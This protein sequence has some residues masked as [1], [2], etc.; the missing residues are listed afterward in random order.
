MEYIFDSDWKYK[1]GNDIIYLVDYNYYNLR[2][3]KVIGT[4][5]ISSGLVD[6][7]KYSVDGFY[8]WVLCDADGFLLEKTLSEFGVNYNN[9]FNNAFSDY[10]NIDALNYS[11]YLL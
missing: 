8:T 7:D 11:N 5:G 3:P 6:L 2:C 10:L 1:N 4:V 9:V